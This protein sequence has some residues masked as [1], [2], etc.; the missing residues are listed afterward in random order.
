MDSPL[1]PTFADF[2]MA[3]VESKLLNE[4]K[5]SNPIFY[6]RY[7]DDIFAI[8]KAT[9]HV[10]WYKARFQRASV[11]KLTH[12]KSTDNKFHFLDIDMIIDAN[13]SFH[14]KVFIKPTDRGLYT[15]FKSHTPLSYKKAIIKTLVYRAYKCSSNWTF[16]HAEIERIK[17]IM[18]NNCYPQ[19]LVESTIKTTINNIIQLSNQEN[20]SSTKIEFYFQLQNLDTFKQ[21]KKWLNDVISEH[22]KP[23]D[24]KIIS[25]R[26]YYKPYKISARFNYTQVSYNTQLA[27]YTQLLE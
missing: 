11:L 3:E 16:F 4:N 1:G 26:A 13:G 21:D 6:K 19:A 15:N 20:N 27:Y 12:E 7:V 17:Q 18:A 8:F 24:D 25:L 14:T 5:V 22:V 10:N 23:K 9:S 2:Y